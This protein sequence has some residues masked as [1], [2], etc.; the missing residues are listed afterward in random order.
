M[1]ISSASVGG[2]SSIGINGQSRMHTRR[3]P[4]VVPITTPLRATAV[5]RNSEYRFSSREKYR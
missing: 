5:S 2:V 3:S 1:S 4:A